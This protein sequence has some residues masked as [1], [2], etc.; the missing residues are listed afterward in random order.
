MNRESSIIAFKKS[1]AKLIFNFTKW[2][3]AIL[4]FFSTLHLL[5]YSNNG[6]VRNVIG[7]SIFR[8]IIVKEEHFSYIM[9]KI[10][11]FKWADEKVLINIS[12]LH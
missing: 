1:Q 5:F 11:L 2:F 12:N 7:I 6:K 8:Y 4:V 9:N 10:F 3:G